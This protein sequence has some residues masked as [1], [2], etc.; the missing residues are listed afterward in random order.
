LKLSYISS[1]K[2]AR[3]ADFTFSEVV[4]KKQFKELN[5]TN[6]KIL[7]ENTSHI[8]YQKKEIN[9]KNNY[10]IFCTND[11]LDLLFRYVRK[12]NI[13]GLTLI[14]NQTDEKISKYKFNK[15]PNQFSKW[16]S[17]NVDFKHNNLI[18]I[19]LGISNGYGKNLMF[20]KDEILVDQE[21]YK[22]NKENLLYL[23]FEKN[24]N[25][26]IRNNLNNYFKN[27]KWSKV[28]TEKK[29]IEEYERD[30]LTSNFVLC[31]EGNG[32]D[33]HRVW[34]ALYSGSIPIVRN[35]DTFKNFNS[36]PILLV[37]NFY[38]ITDQIL[39]KYLNDLNVYDFKELDFNYWVEYLKNEIDN[40]EEITKIQL[41]DNLNALFQLKRSYYK[42]YLKI[43]NGFIR[44]IYKIKNKF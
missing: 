20:D 31:P 30:L 17:V 38:D 43:K 8:C 33:T 24:T 15:L 34:E 14:T 7:Y 40:S 39:K 44:I 36:F 19:P 22:Q 35:R 11:S 42:K 21:K 26:R 27:Y 5:V 9:I 16:L 10:V 32:I 28:V 1:Y 41:N 29:D 37:N 18:P 12:L 4:T 13:T 2:F 3:L 6:Y 23:N 25:I